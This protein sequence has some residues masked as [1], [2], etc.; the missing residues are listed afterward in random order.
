LLGELIGLQPL[1]Q[2]DGVERAVLGCQLAHRAENRAMVAA[3]EILLDQHVGD[4]VQRFR[5]QHQ[6]TKHRLLRLHRLRRQP[7]VVHA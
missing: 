3:V 4:A 6:A 2:G 1:A 7:E 5:R